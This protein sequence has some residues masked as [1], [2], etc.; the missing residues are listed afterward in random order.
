M[1]F[2][3]IALALFSTPLFAFDALVYGGPGACEDGCIDGAVE[4]AKEAGLDPMVV[5]PE[6]FHAS[7]LESARIWIQPGGKSS[8]ASKAMGPQMREDIR[9]F[10]ENGG[11]YVGFC[12]GAFLTTPWV[13]K[14]STPGLGII[15]GRTIGYRADVSIQPMVMDEGVR[16]LYWQG[17]PYFTFN[18]NEAKN[19]RITMKYKMTSQIG[20]VESSYGK[21][22]VSV[23]GLHPEAPKWWAD[24]YGL[25]DQDG[26]DHD[27]AVKMIQK[28]LK[29][30]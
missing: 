28:V 7:L 5:T 11:G 26:L 17:G 9:K 27:I 14:T 12:A 2:F 23:T 21:G 1:K 6:T 15:Q 30:P 13:G 10:I 20:G 22:K 24:S 4:V 19:V 16:Y 8:I 18:A 25:V 3:L 29:A